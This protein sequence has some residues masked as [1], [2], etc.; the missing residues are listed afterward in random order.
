SYYT[1]VHNTALVI[2][3]RKGYR[4]WTEQ[5]GER[6]CAEENGWD[7]MAGDQFGCS[8]SFRFTRLISHYKFRQSA[9][10]SATRP[11]FA[12]PVCSR[13]LATRSC[14]EAKSSW[15]KSSLPSLQ[16]R[17]GRRNSKHFRRFNER[18]C[19]LL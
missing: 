7:F 5:N 14:M 6:I 9:C 17:R 11:R 4:V 19:M 12:N 10:E 16:A 2:L 3:Q 13:N 18:H 15:R 1:N 8:A